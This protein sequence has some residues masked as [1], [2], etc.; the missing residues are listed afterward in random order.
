MINIIWELSDN[1]IICKAPSIKD[2]RS[3]G[4]LSSA[5]A[6]ADKEGRGFFRYGRLH[7]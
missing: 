7:F 6:F 1:F 4:G 5:N 3:Q 2:I